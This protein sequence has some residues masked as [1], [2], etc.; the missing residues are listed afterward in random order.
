MK[1]K[2]IDETSL[3]FKRNL[4]NDI[5]FIKIEM[6]GI[7]IQNIRIIS[8]TRYFNEIHVLI[9]CWWIIRLRVKIENILSIYTFVSSDSCIFYLII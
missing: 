3:E 2:I 1:S 9:F 7:N 6:D 5:F 4:W 8:I